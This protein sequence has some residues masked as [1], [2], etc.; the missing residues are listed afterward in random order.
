MPDYQ[1]FQSKGFS[2]QAPRAQNKRI[3][4]S[5]ERGVNSD[6]ERHQNTFKQDGRGNPQYPI[7]RHGNERVGLDYY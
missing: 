5:Y 6:Y 1:G 4:A 3:E 2:Y 7:R